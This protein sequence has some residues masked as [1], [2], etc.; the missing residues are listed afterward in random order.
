MRELLD[1]VP[2]LD[3]V[4]AGNDLMAAGAVDAIA[5]AGKTV[6][7]DIA[8]AGFDDSPAASATV[9]ALTTMR[10]PFDRI[11]EEMVRMLLGAIDGQRPAA[12]VVPTD[13]VERDS[14]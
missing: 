10:Q 9:P 3:A 8:V 4:F 6:P 2:E 1:R 13:L 11:S 12:L 14:T 7:G 5:A